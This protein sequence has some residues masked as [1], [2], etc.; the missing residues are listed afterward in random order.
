MPYTPGPFSTPHLYVQ[1]GGSLPGGDEW[2]C[3][4]RMQ[5]INQ[6]AV[7]NS[8][9]RLL[10][11][12]SAIKAFHQ[13]AESYISPRVNLEFVK[14]NAV[15]VDGKYIAQQTFQQIFSNTPGGGA[16]TKGF[17]NQ[18]ALAITLKTAVS[19]G[20]AHKGRFYMPIPTTT[21][22]ADGRIS[23]DDQAVIRTSASQ[24]LSQLNSSD[25]GFAVAVMSRKLGSPANQNVIAMDVGRVLD[26]Q[27]RRR[28]KLVE[29]Y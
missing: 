26:T 24:L 20:P 12:A 4:L 8:G 22:A 15:G 14:V 3:G 27:R 11:I 13:R 9:R 7:D 21:V 23:V 6:G 2:S 5:P 18:V 25:A 17:P 16:E 1:W 10:G 19:R 28:N 29:A